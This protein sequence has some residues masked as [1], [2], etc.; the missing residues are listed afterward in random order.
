MQIWLALAVGFSLTMSTV[1]CRGL[2]PQGPAPSLRTSRRLC[3]QG[4]LAMEGGQWDRAEDLLGQAVRTCPSDPDARRHYAQV[5][6][7]RGEPAQAIAQLEDACRLAADNALFRVL[8]AEMQLAAGQVELAGRTAQAAVD[9]APKLAEAWAIRGQVVRVMGRP[10]QALGDYHRALGLAPDDRSI[11][12]EIA[13][14]YRELNEPRRALA[15][16]QSL[17]DS[18]S[19]GEEPKQV[20]YSQGLAY[21]AIERWDEAATSFSAAAQREPTP[22]VLFQL[23]QAQLFVGDPAAAAATARQA[24][25]LDPAHQASRQVLDQ[26]ELVL[27][28]GTLRR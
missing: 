6:W 24:L 22:E 8:L 27:A 5:L 21:A 23:A 2:R 28:P 13:E 1:G 15:A 10:R 3:Q 14:L 25:A 7:H 17:A 4:A 11:Q 18:Y 16:L 9:L 20:L 19:P 26:A 12:L